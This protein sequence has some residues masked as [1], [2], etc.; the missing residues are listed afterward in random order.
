MADEQA[1]Q[2]LG[3]WQV[4]PIA[5]EN[6]MPLAESDGFQDP[7]KDGRG[8]AAVDD[9]PLKPEPAGLENG[10]AEPSGE[11]VANRTGSWPV[12][13]AGLAIVLLCA[14]GVI[15]WLL[16]A[17]RNSDITSLVSTD[18][19]AAPTITRPLSTSSASPEVDLQYQQQDTAPSHLPLPL[20]IQQSEIGGS[21][22]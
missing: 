20:W 8:P 6:P 9:R 7:P 17:D 13:A 4:V 10:R 18:E 15:I 16:A 2:S 11:P 12:L 14:M 5:D 1:T 21:G 22:S 3:D 19:A